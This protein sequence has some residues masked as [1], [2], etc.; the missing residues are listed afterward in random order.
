MNQYRTLN[1]GCGDTD[2]GTDRVDLYITKTTTL[3]CNLE[4]H[5]PF[6]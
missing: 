4:D 2:Y 5:L 3:V 6:E 1:L